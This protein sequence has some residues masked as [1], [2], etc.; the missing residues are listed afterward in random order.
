MS[1][2]FI[3]GDCEKFVSRG[4]RGGAR[5]RHKAVWHNWLRISFHPKRLNY[6]ELH[7]SM[8]PEPERMNKA[9]LRSIEG[10]FIYRDQIFCRRLHNLDSF[11]LKFLAIYR[12]EKIVLSFAIK[13]LL[14]CQRII[15]N[16]AA[17]LRFEVKRFELFCAI[18]ISCERKKNMKEG[19][20]SLIIIFMLPDFSSSS[21]LFR[22]VVFLRSADS[23]ELQLMILR[24]QNLSVRFSSSQLPGFLITTFL[25]S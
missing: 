16:L 13:K 24:K 9:T 21:R 5:K 7:A 18:F 15:K 6:L 17:R 23:P 8:S 14:H 20:K 3:S 11:N 2:I 19:K 22:D 25:C 12:Q 4:H 10:F 1:V